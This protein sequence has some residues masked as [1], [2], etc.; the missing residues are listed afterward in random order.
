MLA[1]GTLA[2]VGAVVALATGVTFGLFSAT[3]PSST[4]SFTAGTVT[5]G[6][7]DA[8]SC[9]VSPG[10][11]QPGDGPTLACTIPWHY[12][13]NVPADLAVDITEA[14]SNGTNPT[15]P[16]YAGTTDYATGAPGLFDG[17]GDGL[18]MTVKDGT[19]PAGSFTYLSGVD[20]KDASATALDLLSNAT[21]DLLAG[22]GMGSGGVNDLFIGKEAAG[23]NGTITVTY[24]APLGMDNS[25][26]ASGSV[27]TFVIHAVQDAH[28][29]SAAC[30]GGDVCGITWN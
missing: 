8:Q 29:S 27:F 26:Q 28:N 22:A 24:K 18:Q 23:A 2:S 3:S 10:V 4:S 1:A 16:T 9:T 14:G 25:Y 6:Q 20:Y 19:N 7:S 17:T 13:G 11:V 21:P 12:S 5:L 30:V 15:T